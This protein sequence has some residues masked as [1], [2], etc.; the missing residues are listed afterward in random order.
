MSSLLRLTLSEYDHMVAVGA[1]ER[2][3][4]GIEMIYGEIR[5]MSPAGPIHDDYVRFLNQWAASFLTPTTGM[6]Q[7]QS[8]LVVGESVPEPD[9]VIIKPGRYLN[10]RACSEDALLLIE[11]AESSLSFDLG[12]KAELY[13]SVG[14]AEYWVIDVTGAQLYCHREPLNGRYAYLKVLAKTELLAPIAFP[15]TALQ[16]SRLFVGDA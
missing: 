16:L 13:A 15:S 3:E 12:Q 10:Q 14:I 6:S 7:V 8:G 1:F 4:R 5:E 2:L 9:L 11:V